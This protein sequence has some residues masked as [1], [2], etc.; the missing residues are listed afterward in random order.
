MSIIELHK[1]AIPSRNCTGCGACM[2]ACRRGCIT[3]KEDAK[4]FRYPVID[5]S[6]CVK[7]MVCVHVCPVI[8]ATPK[9]NANHVYACKNKDESVRLSSSSGGLFTA[10]AEY[11]VDCGGVVFGACFDKDWN[12][13][14]D[15]AER[16]TELIKFR[17]SKYVQSD[18]TQIYPVVEQFLKDGRPV[19]FSG[20]PCQTAGVR[21]FLRKDYDNLILVDFICHGVPSGKVWKKYLQDET[22]RLYARNTV[23]THPVTEKNVSVKDISF[24][25]KSSGWK[26]Y[27]FALTLLSKASAEGKENSVLHSTTAWEHPYMKGFLNNLYLRPSCYA[28]PMKKFGGNSD[29]TMADAWGIEHYIPEWDDDKGV[30]LC[31]PHN[32]KGTD[33]LKK[34]QNIDFREVNND[35]LEK[36]NDAVFC[37]PSKNR[38]TKKFY[39]LMEKNLP[40]NDII[41]MCF[42]PSTLCDKIMWSIN[43][44]IKR[45]VRHK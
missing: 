44:R 39:K 14:H 26:K 22:T 40:F 6:A 45:Y 21:A 28:C 37:N 19:L 30:S 8:N 20:T 23:L 29:M 10:I 5:E 11:V 42:P 13:I 31:V 27:S 1:T 25:D 43:K 2:N 35:I 17:G 18:T 34:L 33:I 16:K 15:Y 32:S 36:H 4:G 24:R 41:R 7:C 9:K 12:V 3:M 38:H